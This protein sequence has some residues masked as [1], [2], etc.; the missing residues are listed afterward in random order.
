MVR[1]PTAPIQPSLPQPVGSPLPSPFEANWTAD[2]T[3]VAVTGS[4]GACGWGTAVGE[5]RAGV[6]WR[7]TRTGAA[8]QLYEDMR[9]F[10]TDGIPFSGALDGHGF[11]ASYF[12]GADYLEYVCR[13][14]GAT[15]TGSF[16]EG[17]TSFDADETLTWGPPGNET[18]VQRRW[19]GRP[20]Q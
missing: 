10:P 4:S 9:N 5:T 7:I 20:M 8:I 3:V 19:T 15:L 18:V 13:F 11:T 1:S 14:K 16:A 6:R 2:A 12:Q 17:F